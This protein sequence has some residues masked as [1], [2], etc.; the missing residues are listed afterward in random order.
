MKEIIITT[1]VMAIIAAC[2]LIR[3]W[4]ID[5]KREAKEEGFIKDNYG[6]GM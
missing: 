5:A 1:G 2:V 6:E 4:W 3:T